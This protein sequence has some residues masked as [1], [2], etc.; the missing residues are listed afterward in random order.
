MSVAQPYEKSGAEEKVSR[1][2]TRRASHHTP[3]AGG[4][5]REDMIVA[6]KNT[7]DW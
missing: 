5:A 1:M 7:P 2:T 3:T 6:D 4:V